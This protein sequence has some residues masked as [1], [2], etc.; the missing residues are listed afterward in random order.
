MHH[1]VGL[2]RR[3]LPQNLSHTG[4]LS[5]LYWRSEIPS[6]TIH[7]L[8]LLSFLFGLTLGTFHRAS[9]PPSHSPRTYST[10]TLIPCIFITHVI[11]SP[12]TGPKKLSKRF[13]GILR[14]LFSCSLCLCCL[15]LVPSI[16]CHYPK[17]QNP[18]GSLERKQLAVQVF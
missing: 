4:L 7:T 12:H 13:V 5:T 14:C 11:R 3:I 1:H 15:S 10:L 9:Y 18:I 16:P 6:L 2:G 8:L 17:K